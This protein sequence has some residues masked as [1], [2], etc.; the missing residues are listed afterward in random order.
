MREQEPGVVGGKRLGAI[1]RKAVSLPQG[2]VVSVRPLVPGTSLPLLVQPAVEGVDL[3]AW[4]ATNR[5]FIEDS[6]LK[7]RGLLFRNFPV[8]TVPEF[9]QFVR[10]SSTGELLE[11]RDRSTA[12]YSVGDKVYVSTIYPADQ[13]IDLHNEG[14]YWMAWPL[15]IYFCSLKVPPQGGATPIA[16]VRGVFRRI[17]PRLR[18]RFIEKRVMYVRNYNDGFGLPWQE[19]FQTTERAVVEEYCRQN[20]IEFEWKDGD[21]LRTRQVRPAVRVHPRTGETVWFNHAAF[22]HISARE[23][24]V[25]EA[26]LSSFKEEDL[27]YNTFY[28]DGSPIE[29]AVVAEIREAYRQEKVVFPWQPGDVLLL[30]NM[31]V[32]HAREPY[33]GERHVVVAMTEKCVAQ[34]V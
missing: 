17:D 16:D 23:E 6:L 29:P 14:T 7:H 18:A 11:Y 33:Q 30:D 24:A 19:V 31:S 8:R 26:L 32:A 4:A 15:K 3:A 12:R 27:P 21:G 20:A 28:G 10:A 25:R 34:E 13:S 5:P 2:E 22:F 9:E 1:K